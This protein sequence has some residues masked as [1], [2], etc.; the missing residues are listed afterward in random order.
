[1]SVDKVH[2][3]HCILYEF[4]KASNTSVACKNLCVVFG[5]YFVYVRTGQ[6]L[7]SK[8][9]S[10]DLSLQESDRSGRPSKIDNDVLRSMLEN[11]PYLTSQE[12]AEEFGIHYT[13]VGDHIKSL[14]NCPV[15]YELLKQGKSINADLHC[16]QLDKLNAAIKEK[17]SALASRKGILFHHDNAR[18]HT[19]MVTQQKLNALGWEVLGHPPFSH[20]IAPS[21][22]YLLRSLPNYLMEKNSS[23]L[24][25]FL[26]QLLTPR[27]R[28]STKRNLYVT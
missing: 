8:F 28:T 21:D 2:L 25:V 18:L 9:R 6:R 17:R 10:G 12:I 16:N 5:K 26:R 13:T 24:K 14:G 15:F 20:D 7:F 27:T 1:M 19:A 11:K 22:Y 4:Q 3:R 23:L